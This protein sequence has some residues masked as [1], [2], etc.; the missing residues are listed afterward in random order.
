MLAYFEHQQIIPS[1]T[2]LR[3]CSVA[4]S[5]Q[6]RNGRQLLHPFP[7][8]QTDELS[9]LIIVKTVL[10][11]NIIRSD[12]RTSNIRRLKEVDKALRLKELY[13]FAKAFIPSL[14][15]SKNAVRH[16]TDI[17]EQYAASRL[18]RLNKSQQMLHV[19][20]FVYHRYQQ[21]MD[22]L[23]V[24]FV[25]THDQSWMVRPITYASNTWNTVP[26]S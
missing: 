16:Y 26:T 10:P 12:Q 5:P 11:L 15:L 9:A 13:T 2:T 3:I 25:I 4:H 23:I 1:Y 8:S 14:K 19:L 18:R 7:A 22:N 20:C 17:A 24:S 21:I 6:K